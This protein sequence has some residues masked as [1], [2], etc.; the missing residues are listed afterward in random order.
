MTLLYD[1][2]SM[3][4]LDRAA[5]ER[6][7]LS[8]LTLMQ[9][10]GAAVWRAIEGDFALREAERIVVVCGSGNN[11][12]DGYV[13]AC[14]ARR[15]GRKVRVLQLGDTQ[16][17]GA[18]AAQCLG[19]LHASGLAL[20]PFTPAALSEADLVVDAIFG[21]GL[22][23]PVEGSAARAIEAINAVNA[24]RVS[25]DL[26]S[27]L[28][29]STGAV[30]GVAVRATVTV[31]F[32][33]QKQGLLTGPAVDYVG[34]LIY[35]NLGVP[36][37]L[38]AAVPATAQRLELQDFSAWSGNPRPRSAHKGQ[39]G[40][41]LVVGGAPGFAGAVRMAGEA[42]LR[43][44]AGLVSIATHPSHAA[45][46]AQQRPELMS[47]AV[48]HPEALAPLLERATVVAVGPGLATDVWGTNL[49][50]RALEGRQ[51]LV[52]DAD[53]LNLLA[54]DPVRRS[55]WILTPH[56]GEAAR[57]LGADA[58]AINRDRFGAAR[59]V[60][61]RYGGVCVLK[62][63]GTIVCAEGEP[64]PGVCP[65][66]NPGMASGGM[67]DVLTGVVAGLVAQGLDLWSA[68]RLGVCVHAMAGD[69]AAKAGERGLLAT[70]L[71]VHLRH[72]VN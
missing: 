35:D 63:K 28:D 45:F 6:H 66:G 54:T 14:L 1:V 32:V 21:T 49:L 16:T 20:E 22:K 18:D 53:G 9:R 52:V 27:G 57:L 64:L 30:L 39:F 19:T 40:H 38:F 59:R 4:A 33:A 2:Q 36:Q 67:G 68:A 34:D 29:A 47:H 61:E 56:P 17:L 3:R 25:V 55:N 5:I 62:G 24:F 44:G 31:T 37:A 15:A 23:R 11:A 10:A 48:A 60:T 51:P 7:G 12:G 43:I 70:D 46:A 72:F 13:V 41:V 50:R 58:G 42:A 26:P 71:M 69:E 65:H 8:G